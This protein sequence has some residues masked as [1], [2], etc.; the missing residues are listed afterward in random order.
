MNASSDSYEG[1]N[2]AEPPPAYVSPKKEDWTPKKEKEGF[3]TLGGPP[4]PNRPIPPVPVERI[5]GEPSGVSNHVSTEKDQEVST[6]E[7]SDYTTGSSVDDIPGTADEVLDISS[8]YSDDPVHGGDAEMDPAQQTEVLS[9][10]PPLV[11]DKRMTKSAT[12]PPR[13]SFHQEGSLEDWS[14]SLFSVIGKRSSVLTRPKGGDAASAKERRRTTIRPTSSLSMTGRN[15]SESGSGGAPAMSSNPL[16]PETGSPSLPDISFGANL[17]LGSHTKPMMNVVKEGD[18]QEQAEEDRAEETLLHDAGERTVDIDTT[19]TAKGVKGVDGSPVTP[20]TPLLPD[21]SLGPNVSSLGKDLEPPAATSSSPSESPRRASIDSLPPSPPPKPKPK[22]APLVLPA[23][24]TLAPP[25]T[26]VITGISGKS[27]VNP[28]FGAKP[29]P[30]P[31]PISP[32]QIRAQL[33][34]APPKSPHLPP[35]LPLPPLKRITSQLNIQPPP[36][37]SQLPLVSSPRKALQA[38]PSDS[39]P[40]SSQTLHPARANPGDRDSG[41]STITVTPATIA[42]AKTEVVRTAVASVIDSDAVSLASWRESVVL[43]ADTEPQ[44]VAYDEPDIGGESP[45][46]QEHGEV[47]D[48]SMVSETSSASLLR[49]GP[50][51]KWPAPPPP[52]VELETDSTPRRISRFRTTSLGRVTQLQA[53]GG[54]VASPVNS[55]SSHGSSDTTSSSTSESAQ[56]TT[57]KGMNGMS[58]SAVPKMKGSLAPE[59]KLLSSRT[60][61]FGGVDI[62]SESGEESETRPHL[63][64]TPL[65]GSHASIPLVTHPL[66]VQLRPYIT[67]RNPMSYFTNLVEIAEGES[68]SVFA[69]RVVSS[70]AES[71][72][73]GQQASTERPIPPGT[74]HV[75]I[76][77]IPLPP[78]SSSPSLSDD[79][80]VSNKLVSVLHELCLLK[81]L[82][83]E[84]LLLLD[85]VYVCSNSTQAEDAGPASTVDTSLWIRM[86][87]MERS[88][89]DII[90]LVAEGLALQERLVGRFASDVGV[91]HQLAW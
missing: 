42:T 12:L 22:P 38:S 72:A 15:E 88:L 63:S 54:T 78:L 80:Q 17:T 67:S 44:T 48:D 85:A 84:H 55:H 2:Y 74:S 32:S 28:L 86:E 9:P 16:S 30:L 37:H 53:M 68:G 66:L 27:P 31:I 43:T 39:R 89:A 49:D 75:A 87:L 21:V 90:G 51:S 14:E 7:N 46:T 29:Q 34:P 36:P 71:R 19:T 35:T 61:T 81:N 91:C 62:E 70:S 56:L 79:S 13:I 20:S 23:V 18:E 65:S 77:R 11:I 45:R 58:P 41:L 76:K 59:A 57:P 64:E 73:Q 52:P 8:Y 26:N 4:P 83:H 6:T 50:Q 47:P 69:A 60:D 3:A 33:R 5:L 25:K 1:E 82:D 40:N 24:F 10:T